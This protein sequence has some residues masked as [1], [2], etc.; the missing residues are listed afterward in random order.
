M[1]AAVASQTRAAFSRADNSNT[2]VVSCHYSLLTTNSGDRRRSNSS[3]SMAERGGGRLDVVMIPWLAFGHMIPFLELSK[4]LAARGH[5]VTFLSTPRNLA[6]LPPL[7][8]PANLSGQIRL[9]PL[10]MP[11]VDGLPEGAESTADVPPE[12]GELIK[13]ACDLLAAPFAAFLAGDGERRKKKP[14]WII[15]DFCYHWI[16]PIADEHKVPC[17]MF[18]ILPAAMNA[19]LGPRWANSKFPRNSRE[20][21]TVPP[22]WI[23]FDSTISFRRREADWAAAAF[24]PNSS[25]V[26]D[27]ERFWRTEEGCRFIINRSCHEIEPPKMFEFLTE[28]FHKPTVPSGL[29]PPPP[30]PPPTTTNPA[31][32]DDDVSRW[33][34]DQPPRSVIYVALGSEAPLTTTDLHELALGLEL[35]GVRFLWALRNKS[36]GADEVLLLPEGFEERTRRRGVV[37]R[38][39]WA[40]QVAALGHGAV[41]GFLTHCGWGSTIEALGFGIPM[42]MLP[43]VVD[44]GVI[45]RAM[46]ERGFGVE[47]ATDDDDGGSFGR[48]GVAAAVRSVMV[49]GE[50]RDL[51]VR[52]VKEMMGVV[53]DETRQEQYIDELVGYL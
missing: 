49:D 34:D 27:A 7:T 36:A 31:V 28:L 1:H 14:D 35:A 48:D 26:P 51:L 38:S 23:P 16:P 44:Q 43:L 24:V 53:R 30:P 39:A 46:A 3:I 20:E 29:L 32:D 9:H 4:R 37:W 8:T 6:R 13:T 42:A 12:K 2:T 10:P 21:F 19:L 15:I 47:I 50:R 41:G 25:G 40:A 22:K 45:A 17:A 18:Q 5:A 52:N 33:L 11:A